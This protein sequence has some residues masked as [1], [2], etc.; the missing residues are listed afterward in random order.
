M[1]NSNSPP[2][3]TSMLRSGWQ[4]HTPIWASTSWQSTGS[5]RVFG[6]ATRTT[7]FSLNMTPSSGDFTTNLVIRPSCKASSRRG[8]RLRAQIAHKSEFRRNPARLAHREC[9][10][11]RSRGPRSPEGSDGFLV[12]DRYQFHE[13]HIVPVYLCS[14]L[15]GEDAKVVARP[16]VHDSA[17]PAI[18][19][20][21]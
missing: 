8:E 7:R 10:L 15:T 5:R 20:A 13:L 14:E 18:V 2:R 16:Q 11:R 6:L 19:Q 3:R 17:L 21:D 12:A 1:N 4:E 9:A